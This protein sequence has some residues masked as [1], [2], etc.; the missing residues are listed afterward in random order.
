[1]KSKYFSKGKKA[2]KKNNN[3]NN[4]NYNTLEYNNPVSTSLYI[5]TILNKH[6]KLINKKNKNKIK[7]YHRNYYNDDEGTP[8][9][10]EGQIKLLDDI[11][12]RDNKKEKKNEIIN[13]ESYSND[14]L[15]NDNINNKRIVD[16]DVGSTYVDGK[17]FNDISLEHIRRNYHI[18]HNKN[19]NYVKEEKQNVS[20]DNKDDFKITRKKLHLLKEEDLNFK[21]EQIISVNKKFDNIIKNLKLSDKELVKYII[22]KKCTN[23]TILKKGKYGTFF[24]CKS[25]NKNVSKKYIDNYIFNEQENTFYKDKNKI[26]FEIEKKNSY[27]IHTFGNIQYAHATNQIINEI[28]KEIISD[29][30]VIKKNKF[31]YKNIIKYISKINMPYP[32]NTCNY[33]PYG[34]AYKRKKNK[35]NIQP[36]KDH[37]EQDKTYQRIEAYKIYKGQEIHK[38]YHTNNKYYKKQTQP[39][40]IYYRFN[41]SF[42]RNNISFMF[43]KH[44]YVVHNKRYDL[45]FLYNKKFIN[46]IESIKNRKGIYKKVLNKYLS[47]YLKNDFFNEINYLPLTW[48]PR[49]D[50]IKAG[51]FP[52]NLSK[53]N[54]KIE[55]FGRL[56]VNNN[57]YLCGCV[58]PLCTYQLIVRYFIYKLFHTCFIYQIPNF[59]FYFFRYYYRIN[60]NIN[61]HKM[62]NYFLKNKYINIF[63]NIYHS[64]YKQILDTIKEEKKSISISLSSS[65]KLEQKEKEKKKN[66]IKNLYLFDQLS[67]NT[68]IFSKQK[69][70]KKIINHY[71]HKKIQKIKRQMNQEIKNICLNEIKKKLPIRIQKVI[72]TYQLQAIYF[73]FK[74]RG[75][76]L[77]ADEMGLGKTLQA[78]SIFYFY[79]LYPVLIITPASLKINWFSEIEKYLPAFDP[80]NVLI[81]NSSN[82]MPK[83]ASSY[84]IIIVSFNIYKKLYNLLKEIQFH[85]IIVDESHFIRTVHYGNQSQLT[86]LLKKKIRKTKHVLFLSGTPSINRPINIFH[87]IKYLINNKNIFPKNKIIFGE[88]YCKKY[89]YRGEKIY[90][91]NLRS[92]EFHYFLNKIVMIRRTINQVFQNNFPSL[93]RFFVY[94]KNDICDN[95]KNSTLTKSPIHENS[96][97]N[98]SE[99]NDHIQSVNVKCGYKMDEMYKMNNLDKNNNIPNMGNFSNILDDQNEYKHVAEIPQYYNVSSSKKPEQSKLN[100]SIIYKQ[101]RKHKNREI[102]NQYFHIDIKSKKE[103]EGVSKIVNALQFI[104]K[105]FPNKKKIIFCYHIMVSK[106]TEDELLK[107]IK[108]KKEKENIS[109]DYVSLNGCIPEKEKIEKILYFQNNINCYYGIFTICSVSHGLDFSFCNLC[110]FMEFPVNFFHLQQCESRLFRKNQKHNT[111][112]F[113]FLLQKGL[114]SDHKTWNRFILCSNSTRS[115]IDG[116]NF[117]NKD[118]IY[119]NIS[120]DALHLINNNQ[121]VI[122]ENI[123][124]Q[125]CDKHDKHVNHQNCFYTNIHTISKT[126]LTIKEN[127]YKNQQIYESKKMCNLKEQIFN[128]SGNHLYTSIKNKSSFMINKCNN[129]IPTIN[130]KKYNNNNNNKNKKVYIK[131]EHVLFQINTF[132]NRIHVYYKNKKT[133]FSIQELDTIKKINKNNQETKNIFILK[134]CAKNFLCNYNKLNTNEKKLIEHK[135]CDINISLLNYWKHID[136]NKSNNKQNNL[137]FQRYIKN[138]PLKHKTYVKAYI[139][140]SFKGKF[141][142]FYYQEWN[143]KENLFKCLHCKNKIP[144]SKNIIH[145]E[146]QIFQYLHQINAQQDIIKRFHK[147]INNLKLKQY[148]NIQKIII[149]NENNLFCEGK[150]RKLYFLKKSSCSL[151]RLIYERDKGICNMCQLDCT[152]LIKQIKNNKYFEINQKIDYFIKMYPLFIENVDHLKK[153]IQKPKEG[154]IWHVDHIL[155]VFKGGG[156]ASFDNLQTLCT[157]CHK[158]KTKNDVKDKKKIKN[159]K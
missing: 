77:I 3:N 39:R 96:F 59:I 33:Y 64:K 146:N 147:E 31:K 148:N 103:E 145:E 8:F 155:P 127:I 94:L 76:I 10:R 49:K 157:F 27:R 48:K 137:I 23:L 54:R 29:I 111:Y 81:I 1:M 41:F 159:K 17:H 108:Q 57:N 7:L 101:E 47:A 97:I 78:I 86:R 89:F 149:C 134:M 38:V 95:I 46:F 129:S 120:N 6:E 109:I 91:E 74:K 82:D 61:K 32:M 153:I 30:I 63:I 44:N 87:Q 56:S 139:E 100:N 73:F 144:L 154:Y 58:F 67:N 151:R 99:D 65:N 16:I 35:K 115:I 84:K 141:E 40:V 142:M 113:Y 55:S 130:H 93:K 140:N 45:L 128:Q 150:C 90:E 138:V 11:I 123:K 125:K 158:K 71:Y 110:F 5:S 19:E 2:S 18:F 62:Y 117:I 119:D 66:Y 106:C 60:N 116:T 34:F 70:E 21:Y 83:C 28:I 4:N 118:L 80:Q 143:S 156:E 122:Q 104:E 135:K 98:N 20:Y 107:I 53:N 13:I 9:K 37:N 36:N 24:F 51:I 92:W 124:E 52:F 121:N 131:K 105:N 15:K 43:R 132:T 102:L 22:C 126:N 50:Y 75:R 85:L 136:N 88:D 68:Y 25:C 42:C 79:H 72:L 114:G 133:N 69:I 112:V 152:N 14:Q 26:S 12:A